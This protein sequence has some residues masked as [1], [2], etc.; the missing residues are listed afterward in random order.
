MAT[1]P[2]S[3]SKKPR[4][5]PKNTPE[6]PQELP[7]KSEAEGVKRARL[8]TN[9][10]GKGVVVVSKTAPKGTVTEVTAPETQANAPDD[11][12][13]NPKPKPVKAGDLSI[14]DT[15]G[16]L[17]GPA[18]CHGHDEVGYT[19]N[20]VECKSQLTTSLDHFQRYS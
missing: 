1:A 13:A 8:A 6:T 12:T 18:H 3:N 11:K 15:N 5:R 9:A 20:C 4:S 2:T 7:Q 14:E 10:T 17:W 19:P 16:R